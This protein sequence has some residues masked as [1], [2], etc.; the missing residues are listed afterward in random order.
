MS[1][2]AQPSASNMLVFVLSFNKVRDLMF[3]SSRIIISLLVL[4]QYN[5]YFHYRDTHT[6]GFEH[7]SIPD[8]LRHQYFGLG[9]KY[10]LC[11]SLLLVAYL[12][13]AKG[14]KSLW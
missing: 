4:K 5:I 2:F 1:E 3:Y 7:F 12:A 10:H 6:L 13:S 9:G 8:K 14:I 11:K